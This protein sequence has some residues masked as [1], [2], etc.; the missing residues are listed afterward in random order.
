MTVSDRDIQSTA[1]LCIKRHGASA[2]YFAAG[3]VDELLEEGARRRQ[4]VAAHPRRDRM[5]AGDGAGGRGEAL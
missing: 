4:E 3:R 1:R 2:A 5:P